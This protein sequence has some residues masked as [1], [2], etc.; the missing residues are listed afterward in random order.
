MVNKQL[1]PELKLSLEQALKYGF[2]HFV[3]TDRRTSHGKPRVILLYHSSLTE[4]SRFITNSDL[5]GS[6][7]IHCTAVALNSPS[8]YLRSC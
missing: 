5:R 3:A 6:L 2:D 1:S 7:T 4:C 8:Y